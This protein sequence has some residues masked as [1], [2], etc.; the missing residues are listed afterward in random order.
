MNQS[1]DTAQHYYQRG[2]KAYQAGKLRDALALL[3][4]ALALAPEQASVQYNMALCRYQLQEYPAAIALLERLIEQAGG[5]KEFLWLLAACQYA[6]ADYPAAA[7]C[8]Q[9]LLA[10]EPEN[11]DVLFNLA[12]CCYQLG[13]LDMAADHYRTILSLDKQHRD[14]RFNLAVILEQ[15]NQLDDA[16]TLYEKLQAADSDDIEAQIN[17]AA[18]LQA[19]GRYREA[20]KVLEV[21][22]DKR[23]DDDAIAYQLAAVTGAQVEQAPAAYVSR[24]FDRYAMH[25]DRHMQ[26]QLHSRVPELLQQAIA[27]YAAQQTSPW[28]V[29]DLGCGTG[30]SAECLREKKHRLVGVD[31]SAQMLAYAE[32]KALYDELLQADVVTAAQQYQDEFDV[33]IA[34]DVL[35]YVGE[36]RPLLEAVHTA[37]RPNGVFVFTVETTAD[38]FSLQQ[39]GR[40]AHSDAYIKQLAQQHGFQLGYEQAST[41]RQQHGKAVTGKVF[42][43]VKI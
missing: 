36:L 22:Q 7:R 5:H 10:L 1:L 43:L 19:L 8:F 11:L 40:F 17:L 21:L 23:P 30:L 28:Q 2:V 34:G 37:L 26:E 18:T 25:Y 4:K 29:L 14:A 31:L 38:E 39:T 33:I 12:A 20:T 15:K 24:L 27:N 41:L 9:S 16:L 13:Q 42:S 6:A 32:Q 35:V 3:E